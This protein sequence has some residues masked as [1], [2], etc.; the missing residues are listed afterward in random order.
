MRVSKPMEMRGDEI[1][2]VR[3]KIRKPVREGNEGEHTQPK[4]RI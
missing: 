2:R 3:S 1:A 4:G